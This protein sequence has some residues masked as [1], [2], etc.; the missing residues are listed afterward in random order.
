MNPPAP[1]RVLPPRRFRELLDAAPD[2]I[3]EVDEHGHILLMNAA[4]EIIFGYSRAELVGQPVEI[5]VPE[6]ARGTHV[7]KRAGYW[8]NPHSRPMGQ[9][10]TLYGMRKD[11]SRF[12]VEI[13]LSP[14]HTE[15]GLRVGAIIRDV[16]ERKRAE[17]EFRAMEERLKRE[18]TETN[19]ELQE[20]NEAV[21][22]ANQ[23]K[24]EFLASMSHELRTPLHT[25]IGF[26]ELLA[27]EIQGPLNEKQRRFVEHIH[28]DS[29]HLLE[30]INDILD[31]TKIESG[32]VELRLE[33]FEGAT[34]MEEVLA[35]CR[36]RAATSSVRIVSAFPVSLTLNADRLR[37]K[38]VLFNLMS[39][40]IK[41]T[42]AGGAVTVSAAP[43]EQPGFWNISVRDTGVGIPANQ[44][45]AIFDKFYQVGST[46]RGVR[47]G[48]GLGLAITRQIVEMHGG[49]IS[50]QSEPGAGSC[51]T[52]SLPG[53]TK[54]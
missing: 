33:D 46:T 35:S 4:T 8:G 13:S 36:P 42:P 47:E 54:E 25:I 29:Q 37:V 53:G 18:L 52:F 43:G 45:E 11:G 23:L 14:V 31:L 7:A 28:R 21:E 20:R 6:S 40:A 51:F 41:F 34:V 50:V 32:K 49:N 15:E 39:N 1:D 44:H 30:L 17:L 12:P 10:L 16:T 9:G 38:E 5:L 48:T 26:S 3:I 24:S 19:I 27:E 22:R 2:A